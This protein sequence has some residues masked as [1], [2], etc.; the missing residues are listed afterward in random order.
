MNHPGQP[1]AT[2]FD[3]VRPYDLEVVAHVEGSVAGMYAIRRDLAALNLPPEAKPT[4]Y[5]CR[6]L[7]RDQRRLVREMSSDLARA[8]AAFKFGL[9]EVRNLRREDGRLENVVAPRTRDREML[10]DEVLD[11]LGVGDDDITDIGGVVYRRSFLGQ[12]MPLHCPVPASS[13]D[14]YGAAVS[15]LAARKTAT[16]TAPASSSD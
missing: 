14:A 12:G 11:S 1:L 5:R 13:Q 3:V 8:E 9:V 16:E 15:H 6:V 2:V 10:S 7:T 4:I